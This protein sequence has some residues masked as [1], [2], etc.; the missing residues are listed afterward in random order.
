MRTRDVTAGCTV[1]LHTL[2]VP[3]L[4]T[5]LVWG[6]LVSTFKLLPG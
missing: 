3:H 5:L 1:P 6:R 4:G 2:S